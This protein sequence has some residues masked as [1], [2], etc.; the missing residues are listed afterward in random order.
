MFNDQIIRGKDISI[1]LKLGKN[2]QKSAVLEDPGKQLIWMDTFTFK[3]TWEETIKFVIYIHHDKKPIPTYYT[4]VN[5]RDL[6]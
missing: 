3:R 4:E 5:I 6:F 1:E 2:E